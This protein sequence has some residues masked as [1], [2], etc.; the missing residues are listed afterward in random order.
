MED[1]AGLTPNTATRFAIVMIGTLD[2]TARLSVH[3][4]AAKGVFVN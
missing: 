2:H 4:S 3:F 1:C